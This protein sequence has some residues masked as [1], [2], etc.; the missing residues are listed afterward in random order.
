M[1]I[2][3]ISD[4]YIIFVVGLVCFYVFYSC[5]AGGYEDIIIRKDREVVEG[6]GLGVVRLLVYDRAGI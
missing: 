1:A 2:I 5:L 3:I 4:I 6:L